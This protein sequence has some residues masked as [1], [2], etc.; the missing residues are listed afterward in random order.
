MAEDIADRVV[1][2]LVAELDR[3]MSAKA[4]AASGMFI[5]AIIDAMAW[6]L[7]A[8]GEVKGADY[9]AWVD[10]YMPDNQ[11]HEYHYD[12]VDLYKGR[13]ALLH[14]FATAAKHT[15][16]FAF[17][18]CGPHRYRRDIDASLVILSIEQFRDDLWNAVARF[19]RAARARPDW[20]DIEKRFASMYAT[21][22]REG[23][24]W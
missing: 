3:T 16:K 21:K 22:K 5:F 1:A 20:P 12:G 8:D 18:D 17:V 9:I 4:W 15:K 6:A 13:C 10:E 14:N 2:T 11:P 24:T 19:L 23:D 7:K